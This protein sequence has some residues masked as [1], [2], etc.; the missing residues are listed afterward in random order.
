M[1]PVY[2]LFILLTISIFASLAG[3]FLRL[4]FQE[5]SFWGWGQ[6]SGESKEIGAFF[7]NLLTYPWGFI[8]RKPYEQV[9]T[10][11]TL[12]II[13]VPGY[14]LNRL[15]TFFLAFYL[16]RKGHPW[17]WCINHP[18]YK[19]DLLAFAKELDRKI[20]WYTHYTQQDKVHIIAHSM[21]GIVS[22]LS[23]QKHQSPIASLTTLGTPWKG[24]KMHMLGL[25]KHVRQLAP[26]HPIIQKMSLPPFPHLA[27]T[28]DLDWILLPSENA[29]LKNMQNTQIKNIGHFGLLIS[30]N[31]FQKTH[32][33]LC[34]YDCT[35]SLCDG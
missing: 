15:S 33:F 7:L 12:P 28:A 9:G 17:V 26:G 35:D 10:Q 4:I 24:T 21:G 30:H 29:I 22:M 6:W 5:R 11:K 3:T 1:L 34:S 8:H 13:L 23:H 31:C 2:L 20:Q 18:I 25:G 32:Q 14:G 27:I 16:R 19:D